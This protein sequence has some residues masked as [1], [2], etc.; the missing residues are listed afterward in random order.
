MFSKKYSLI[1]VIIFFIIGVIMGWFTYFFH[2]D[3]YTADEKSSEHRQGGYN[4][5]NPL[6][7]CN[8]DIPANEIK[9][10]KNELVDYIN[11]EKDKFDIKLNSVYFRDLNN[12]PWIGINEKEKFSPASMLKVPLMM[13]ALK[14]AENNPE[15]LREKIKINKLNNSGIQFIKPSQSMEVDKSYT[16][17][18]LIYRMIVYSDNNAQAEIFNFIGDEATAK[19]YSELGI[20]VPTAGTNENFMSV[21][22]YASF[23]RILYNA[24]Y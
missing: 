11:Q 5:I 2:I 16:L 24:S 4:Y 7:E 1:M 14:L 15:I 9:S 23:F 13:S 6:L 19:S 22:E 21:K 17:D 12:G 20:T 18:E 8:N 3:I 10:F